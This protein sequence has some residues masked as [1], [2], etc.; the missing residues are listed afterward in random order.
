MWRFIGSALAIWL[1]IVSSVSACEL[2]QLTIGILNSYPSVADRLAR[3]MTPEEILAIEQKNLADALRS[4]F[5]RLTD[6]TQASVDCFN[7]A[8]IERHELN[9]RCLSTGVG[10]CGK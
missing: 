9:I 2:T 1:A 7:T 3:G 10:P 6:E 4:P 5:R 8:I